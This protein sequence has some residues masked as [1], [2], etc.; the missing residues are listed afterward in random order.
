MRLALTLASLATLAFAEA[1]IAQP[2][3]TPVSYSPQFQ[4]ALT[5]ELGEREGAYLSGELSR[6]VN[7]A[8]ER[9]GLGAGSTV[10]VSIISADPNRPTMQ[11]LHRRIDLDTAS[12][13]VGGAEFHAL[14]KAADGSTVGEVTHRV[15]DYSL[16]D[17]VG[18]P[19]TWTTAERA[20]NQFAEKVADAY[21]AH[22]HAQ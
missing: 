7:A 5:R 16:A 20:I 6:A 13:A 10:E 4:T 18:P 21:E 3:V 14:I 17:L 9:R 19:T 15:Y 8:L 2:V 22:T 1:A 11:Q 12:V